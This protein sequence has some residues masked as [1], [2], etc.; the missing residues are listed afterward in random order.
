MSQ[1][2]LSAS[3]EYICYGS[4]VYFYS[5]SA[6][7]ALERQSLTSVQ[8]LTTKVDPRAVKHHFFPLKSR[9]G[10]VELLEC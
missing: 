4:T 3:F 9:F 7:I 1:L 5:S 8:I 2:V 6:G 10:G